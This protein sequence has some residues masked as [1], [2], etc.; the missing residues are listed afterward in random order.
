MYDISLLSF[1]IFHVLKCEYFNHYLHNA[2]M[3]TIVNNVQMID[4]SILDWD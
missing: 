3:Y 4:F 1:L 2:Y